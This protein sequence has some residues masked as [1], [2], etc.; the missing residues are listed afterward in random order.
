MSRI[1]SNVQLSTPFPLGGSN[2][3]RFSHLHTTI[4]L[5]QNAMP[6]DGSLSERALFSTSASRRDR[7]KAWPLFCRQCSKPKLPKQLSVARRFSFR[8][9]F[10]LRSNSFSE[11]RGLATSIRREMR[12][13]KLRGC[14]SIVA[15]ASRR[16]YLRPYLKILFPI[17]RRSSYGCSSLGKRLASAP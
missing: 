10:H 9:T 4:L 7:F 8:P 3:L 1:S 13:W 11:R 6:S 15:A 12:G 16:K 17:K 2:D 5:S 14:S